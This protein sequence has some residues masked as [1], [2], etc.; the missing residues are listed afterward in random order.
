K[1]LFSTFLDQ[2]FFQPLAESLRNGGS[3]GGFGGFIGSLIGSVIG[4]PGRA[5]GGPVSAGRLYR[6]NESSGSGQPEYFQPANS[7][8]IIPLGR[9]NQV[10]A[11][12]GA[13]HAGGMATVRLELSGDIDARIQQQSAGVAIEVVRAAAPGLTERAVN[14]T[15][16]RSSRPTI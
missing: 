9:V 12:A 11:R 7:G 2:V 4:I 15:F 14:E 6:I 10:A 5:S 16:R 1:D 8:N 13:G 3:G